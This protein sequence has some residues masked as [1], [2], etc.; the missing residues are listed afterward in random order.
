MTKKNILKYSLIGFVLLS[1]F[2]SWFSVFSTS[3]ISGTSAWSLSIVFF[4]LFIIAMCLAT[5]LINQ[6]IVVEI[7]VA[8]TFLSSLIFTFFLWYFVI[9]LFAVLLVLAGLREIRKD[10]DLN[11]KVDLWKSLYVGK[12]KI[13]LALALLISSQYFFMTNSPNG[14][15]TIPK[16]DFSSVTSK[17]IQPILVMINPNFKSVQKEGLTVD[18]FIIQSQQKK[19]DASTNPIFSEEMIDQQIPSNLPSEQRTELKKEALKQISDSQT[20]L[21]QKN[22]ELVIQEGRKQL[23]Q[24]I[25]HAVNGNEK[26]ADVFAGL[27]DKKINDFFQPK[28]EGDSRSSLYSYIVAT[29][30]FLTIWPLGSIMALL[31]FAIVIL[32]FK[33]LVYCGLVEIK[34]VTVQREM[35]A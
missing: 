21:S 29:I 23:S 1:G 27:I 8:I 19:D 32:V 10:L 26:I 22:N 5:I 4:S 16:L 18:Q 17:L 28:I 15:K 13:V 9:L 20:Q 2:L 3:K 11:I 31:W 30:L 6:E 35:I 34:T 25:G 12:F 24:M 7:V 14:Q 33:T